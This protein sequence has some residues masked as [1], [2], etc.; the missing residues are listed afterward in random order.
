MV[1]YQDIWYRSSDGL[2]LYARDYRCRDAAS[3]APPTVLCLHGLTR[4]SADFHR[5]ALHLAQR[6]R[7]ISVD[8]RGRGQSEYDSE[9]SRY[10]PATYV[11]DMFTLLD[12]Q[13]VAEA[14]LIGTSMGG[15]MSL[16][17]AAMAPQRVGAIV[18]N[19]IGPEVDPV[20]LARIRSYVGK[21]RPVRNWDEAVAQARAINAAAF[22]DFSDEE[23]LE[24]TRGVYRDDHGIPV[25]AYDPAISGPMDD[26]DSDA[27]PD[28]LWPLFDAALAIPML[29][30]RGDSSDI[31]ARACVLQMQARKADL[32]V[33]EIPGRGHAPTLNEA[34][35]RAAI[36]DF[37]RRADPR[38]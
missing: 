11:H 9:P 2:T 23:W 33:V 37:L 22:A 17:M 1:A 34:I 20:G 16:V 38:G 6:Y 19:D 29:V 31:L 24:F 30:I 32:Q 8:Q 4:N 14:I 12:Q 36:D 28:D 5:L 25:L 10:T 7:V 26:E 21:S 15:L 27:V 13:G 3:A 35:S 18:L